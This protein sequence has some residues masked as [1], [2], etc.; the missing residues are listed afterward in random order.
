MRSFIDSHSSQIKVA[1]NFHSFGNLFVHPFNYDDSQN[2]HLRAVRKEA[3]EIYNEIWTEGG[4]PVGNRKG[5]GATTVR[6]RANG[7]A[8]DWMFGT[9]GIIAA[10]PELGINDW[11]SNIFFIKQ[12]AVIREVILQNY[13]WVLHTIK[14][15]GVQQDMK[16]EGTSE[17]I[18]G[19]HM[20]ILLDLSVKNKGLSDEG[21]GTF[22]LVVPTN[23]LRLDSR[24]LVESEY[25]T[26]LEIQPSKKAKA[27]I[28]EIKL[29]QTLPSRESAT[30]R[31]NLT[32]NTTLLGPDHF[33]PTAQMLDDESPVQVLLIKYK[34]FPEDAIEKT[35]WV[36]NTAIG[37]EKR[38]L[39]ELL[40]P[41]FSH[42]TP[43][44]ELY[45]VLEILGLLAVVLVTVCAL[46]EK[47][48]QRRKA[49]AEEAAA[50]ED[51]DEFRNVDVLSDEV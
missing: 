30:L 37:I 43:I 42:D 38:V 48:K 35:L 51:Y 40:Q 7:E 28:Y 47:V 27:T 4:F 5:N 10:S 9:H 17:V 6:Y 12:K 13:R 23:L 26:E 3:P 18:G 36:N 21:E 41:H 16:V 32:L 8:S 45:I 29:N 2:E 11:R 1:L 33:K 19:S 24:D 46:W 31:L 14:K 49:R 15:A 39:V 25:E 20:L 44:H 22:K 34:E 50:R